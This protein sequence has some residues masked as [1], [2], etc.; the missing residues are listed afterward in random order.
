MRRLHAPEAGG[1]VQR[2]GCPPPLRRLGLRPLSRRQ[3]AARRA[4]AAEPGRLLPSPLE[5]HDVSY[6]GR[7]LT[8]GA[9]APPFLDLK[10]TSWLSNIQYAW[11]ALFFAEITLRS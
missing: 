1:G 11:L 10:L 5:G 9:S 6:T 2:R 7:E 3:G 4:L 8:V